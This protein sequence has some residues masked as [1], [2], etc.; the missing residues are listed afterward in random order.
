MPEMD[1]EPIAV[2]YAVNKFR[3]YPEGQPT[4]VQTD[5]LRLVRA[6]TKKTD[7]AF[8]MPRRYLL[9]IAQFVDQLYYLTSER[10]VA[11]AL[12]R[13]AERW[14][15]GSSHLHNTAVDD[16]LPDE[17]SPHAL[18]ETVWSVTRFFS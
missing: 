17:D 9:K 1:R 12:S 11:D 2:S 6:L 15:C 14:Q 10:N 4:V 18:S 5:D 16:T 7:M 13:I 8:P 3:S